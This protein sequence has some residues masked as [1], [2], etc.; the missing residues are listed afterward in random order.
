MLSLRRKN[1]TA[2]TAKLVHILLVRRA[3]YLAIIEPS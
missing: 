1:S 3:V 2:G